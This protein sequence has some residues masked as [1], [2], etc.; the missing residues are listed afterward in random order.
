MEDNTV[1][2]MEKQKEFNRLNDIAIKNVAGI[3]YDLQS[4]KLPLPNTSFGKFAQ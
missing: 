4:V 3:L 1:S 2:K